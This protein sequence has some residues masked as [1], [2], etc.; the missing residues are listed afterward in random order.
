MNSLMH[1][2]P[3]DRLLNPFAAG[4]PRMYEN[5]NEARLRPRVDI[6]EEKDRFIL[7]ADLPGVKKDD[8]RVEVEGDQ[9]T[10]SATREQHAK[11]EGKS[12][13]SERYQRVHFVRSFSLGDSVDAEH[14]EGKLEEGVLRLSLPKL[15]KALPR[16]IEVG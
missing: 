15:A 3:V 14:I 10:L 9:L 13:H 8:L 16:R 7:Y 2:S 12:L 6:R 1:C 5:E 4:S 11:D